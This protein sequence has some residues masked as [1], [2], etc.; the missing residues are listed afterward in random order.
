MLRLKACA[1]TVSK[2]KEEEEGFL[3]TVDVLILA[4][5]FAY[6]GVFFI[7]GI[8]ESSFRYCYR[9]LDYFFSVFF[10]FASIFPK[11]KPFQWLRV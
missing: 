3:I 10:L 2:N 6:L 4:V 11:E 1:N 8:A 5:Y 7:V 9:Y